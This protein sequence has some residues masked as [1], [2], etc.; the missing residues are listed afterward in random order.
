MYH[1]LRAS[2]SRV[3]THVIQNNTRLL[4][5]NLFALL[6]DR[7]CD[8]VDDN[9]DD[10]AGGG[11]VERKGDEIDERQHGDTVEEEEKEDHAVNT[12]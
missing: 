10:V 11:D 8:E 9:D 6:K 1:L 3:C 2:H 5:I 7:T 4:W 12:Q